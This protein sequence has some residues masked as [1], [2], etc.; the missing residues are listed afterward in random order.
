LGF[1]NGVYDFSIGEFRKG[2]PDDYITKTVGYN[3]PDGSSG[4][5]ND[6]NEFLKKVYPNEQV[7]R[8]VLQLQAQAL[9]GNKINDIV[10]THTGTGGNGKSVE[11]DIIK[12]VFGDYFTEIPAGMIT[13]QNKQGYNTGDPFVQQLQGIRYG[14]VNEPDEKAK[15]NESLIKTIG[16]QECVKYR[17]LYSND[18]VE[19][20]IQFKLHIYCNKKLD[21]NGDDGGMRRR[22]KVVDY[23]SKFDEN[24]TED[25]F[26][27]HIYMQD[28]KLSSVVK[29]WRQDY[30]KMLLSLYKHGDDFDYKAYEPV[31]VR[32]ATQEYTNSNNDVLKFMGEF[33]EKT[34]NKEDYITL[35]Q[36]SSLY[37]C[38]KQY[39]QS[40]LK[41]LKSLVER[42][43]NEK[44][45]EK[46]KVK[47]EGK[48]RDVRNYLI[49]WRKRI[50]EDDEDD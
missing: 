30:M 42:E 28:A 29:L 2:R 12:R 3:F 37:Q 4:Y 13:S 19:L 9:C 18:P 36:I 45:K 33:F 7:R 39:N 1:D 35:T 44:F 25:D 27:N 49:G 14:S 20:N 40:K 24:A 41:D 46:G 15:L 5:E 11:K 6:I 50:D 10:L 16:S 23:I 43:I 8:Y 48:F 47:V 38:M 32:E 31:S 22:L 26:E 21:F 17:V 34:G